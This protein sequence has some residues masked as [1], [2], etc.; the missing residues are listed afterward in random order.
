VVVQLTL[1]RIIRIVAVMQEL[2]F[3]SSY[4]DAYVPA[5]VMSQVEM[6]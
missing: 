1:M 2:I 6:V 3:R 4:R 5:R